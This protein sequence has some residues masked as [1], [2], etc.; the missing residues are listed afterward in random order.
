[1]PD[2]PVLRVLESS[3]D[4]DALVVSVQGE[5][6]IATVDLLSDR[7]AH[8]CERGIPVTVDLRRV[9]FIDCVGLRLLLEAHKD[10]VAA[11]RR[12]DFIQGPRAVER[13]F[14]LTG[15]LE[16]M[17]FTAPAAAPAAAA[18]SA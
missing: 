7:L 5:L 16:D 3:I 17:P 4:E 14:E 6:D 10:A 18:F 13:V 1:M 8:V 15:T 2:Q 11:D 12:L 9:S